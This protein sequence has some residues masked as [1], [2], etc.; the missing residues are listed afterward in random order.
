MQPCQHWKSTVSSGALD[1]TG[2]HQ[3]VQTVL[4]QFGTSVLT[5]RERDV[6]Q[7]LLKGYPSKRVAREL[8]ISGH[9]EQAHRKNIYQKLDLSS[10]SELFSLFFDAL[11]QP[12]D[13]DADP[14]V[15][16]RNNPSPT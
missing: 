7:L 10:H 16:L 14:L 12:C 3:H 2:L 1:E 8:G 13:S 4:Q 15:A 6:V 5:P 9:T 11:V